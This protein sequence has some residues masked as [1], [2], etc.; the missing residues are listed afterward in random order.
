MELRIAQATGDLVETAK[1]TKHLTLLS[2]GEGLKFFCPILFHTTILLHIPPE[3]QDPICE[4]HICLVEGN[5]LG[6][7]GHYLLIFSH[8]KFRGGNLDKGEL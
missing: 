2:E 5:I 6:E 1:Q 3:K 8:N 4:F 7:E